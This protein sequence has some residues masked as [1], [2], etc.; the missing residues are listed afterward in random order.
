MLNSISSQCNVNIM[1]GC[2]GGGGK[3]D[4]DPLKIH[5][6]I[7]I[8]SNTGLDPLKNPLNNHKSTCGLQWRFISL[9]TMARY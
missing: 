7:S 8:F 6:N 5:K 9:P 4:P 3:G 2:R 1:R